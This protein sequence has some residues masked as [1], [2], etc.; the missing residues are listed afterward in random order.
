VLHLYGRY[1]CANKFAGE[2]DLFEALANAKKHYKIDQNKLVVRGFSMGGGST[3]QFGSHFGGYWAAVQPGAGFGETKE[4]MR[5]GTAPDKPLPPEWEQ[6]LW[7]WYDS[8]GYVANLSNTTTVAYSGEIDGQRQAANIMVRYAEK[9][10]VKIDQVI[11]PNT[12]HRILPE[13]K[14]EIEALVTA[15]VEKH[16]ATPNKVRFVTYTLIYHRMDWVQ[17]DGMEKEWERAEVNAERDGG[18]VKVETKNVSAFRLDLKNL[19]AVVLDGQQLPPGGGT[20]SIVFHKEGSLWVTGAPPK[21]VK[22]THICGPID[23]AFMSSF[24]FVRPTGKPMNDKLGE[25]TKAE[26]EHATDFWRKVFRGE[27]PV[28]D[29]LAIT[30]QDIANSNL[31]L[32]GDPSSNAMLAKVLNCRIL[33]T[34]QLPIQWTNDKLVFAEKSYDAAHVAPVMI[35]PNP[36]NPARYVVIN[37]GPTFREQALLNNADQTPKLPDWAIV[38]LNTPPGP[39]WPGEILS[40]GFFDEHWALRMTKPE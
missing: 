3:W 24:I 25:W 9:E 23:H 22:N 1:C 35:F 16:E 6:T 5:L 28:K 37:S 13:S 36:F 38:D 26:F 8:T 11:G 14:P 18:K 32:W 27:A 30:P 29:D 12:P 39:K 10:G 31:V 40:A 2:R 19:E 33:G 34:P 20:E 7:Q 21:G 17:I 15:G 4:F